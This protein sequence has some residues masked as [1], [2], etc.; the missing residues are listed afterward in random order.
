[1]EPTARDYESCSEP[2]IHDAVETTRR[3]HARI[4]SCGSSNEQCRHKRPYRRLPGFVRSI[5]VILGATIALRGR[6]SASNPLELNGGSCLAMAGKDC[7]ALAVDRR[8]GLEGQ[9]V[10]TEAKRVLKVRHEVAFRSAIVDA[11]VSKLPKG[12]IAAEESSKGRWPY[13]CATA[14][15]MPQVKACCLKS[16]VFTSLFVFSP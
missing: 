9:L 5:V 11:A 13:G 4:Y 8:F 6:V 15:R 1:M 7:V 3:K 2:R 10:S 14:W 16:V 12:S